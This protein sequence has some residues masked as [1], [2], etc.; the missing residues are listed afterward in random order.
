VTEANQVYA[1]DL[2]NLSALVT[3][4]SDMQLHGSFSQ[5]RPDLGS[6]FTCPH[7][8]KRRR[9]NAE[10]CCNPSFA[11]TQRAWTPELGFHQ[12]E[13]PERS[14]SNPF[15]KVFIKKFTHKRHGQSKKFKLR[16]LIA[17]F[18]RNFGG[19]EELKAAAAEMHVKVPDLIGIPPFAEKYLAWKQERQ[20][21]A[22][23]RRARTSRRINRSN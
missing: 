6:M 15:S 17:I 18:N 5:R 12:T 3:W 1:K 16:E 8:H 19:N 22:A 10:R 23:R 20:D 14:N 21:R 9:A 4:A 2:S 7:C 13:C 11:T